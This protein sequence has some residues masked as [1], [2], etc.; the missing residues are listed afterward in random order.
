ME[1]FTLEVGKFSWVV[2]ALTGAGILSKL[3]NCFPYCLLKEVERRDN[4]P[5]RHLAAG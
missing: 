1:F 4:L 5:A 3:Q 2:E